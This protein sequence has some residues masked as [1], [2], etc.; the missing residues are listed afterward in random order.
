MQEDCL[1]CRIAAGLI[2]ATRVLETE[3]AIAF[4]DIAPQAPTHVLVIPREH[5]AGFSALPAGSRLWT[6]LL[7]AAQTVAIGEGLR[8][9][10]RIVVNEGE[11]GGQTV[12]HLHLHVLGGRH[13]GWPPG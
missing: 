1:F 3:A 6:D 2:P 11:H 8:D 4:R 7:G 13:L 9:G 10:F 5:V 12:G